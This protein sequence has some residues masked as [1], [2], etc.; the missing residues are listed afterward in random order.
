[1]ILKEEKYVEILRESTDNISF[2]LVLY[3]NGTVAL[4]QKYPIIIPV[5]N[6]VGNWEVDGFI[7]LSSINNSVLEIL[8]M[9]NSMTSRYISNKELR[10]KIEEATKLLG[11][12]LPPRV[13]LGV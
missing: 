7:K 1:M 5:S 12:Q 11:I 2:T 4:L 13:L 3:N 9:W 6:T 8:K 10:E